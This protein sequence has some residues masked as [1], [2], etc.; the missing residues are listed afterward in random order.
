MNYTITLNE[1]KKTRYPLLFLLFAFLFENKFTEIIS[2]LLVK[3]LFSS[4]IYS[5]KILDAFF[6]LSICVIVG[7]LT[8]Y[9]IKGYKISTLLGY[10][11]IAVSIIH[12]K[13]RFFSFE[14]SY[15]HL[16]TK[17]LSSFAYIDILFALVISITI[18]YLVVIISSFLK[19]KNTINST[20]GFYSDV[21]LNLINKELDSLNRLEY[22]KELKIKLLATISTEASFAIGI[23]GK[24][25]SGKTT[26]ITTLE[27]LLKKERE[28]IQ[29]KFNP[30]MAGSTEKIVE[31]FFA[32]LSSTLGSYDGNLKN[33][34]ITYSKD[35]IKSMDFNNMT[36]LKNLFE[37][38]DKNLSLNDQYE[39][40]STS[41][42]K[43]NKRLIIYIDDVDR[44][45]KKEVLEVLR[46]I[47]NTANFKNT[48]FIVAFDRN[49]LTASI[50]D[51]LA[52]NTDTYIEKIFQLE[53]Y[54]PISIDK[55][56][57][58]KIFYQEL[59][60]YLSAKQKEVIEY[61]KSPTE[62]SFWGAG[63]QIPNIEKYIINL[64]DVKRFLNVFLLNFDRIK[65]NVYLPDYIAI[66]ILRLKFPDVYYELY[67]NRSKYLNSGKNNAY[68]TEAGKL[69]LNYPDK[70]EM[71]LENSI[72][73]SELKSNLAFYSLSDK[74]ADDSVRLVSSI[75]PPN[76]NFSRHKRSLYNN[77]LSI[78]E[79][80]CFDR[81][82]D[83]SLEGRLNQIE[84]E[85]A[86][87]KDTK[88]FKAFIEKS[89]ANNIVTDLQ[90]SLE[91]TFVNN[92]EEFKKLVLGIVYFA[93][94]PIPNNIRY[95]NGFNANSFI[96]I[97]GGIQKEHNEVIKII[98]KENESEYTKFIWELFRDPVNTDYSFY[99]FQFGIYL[100]K[101]Y[102]SYEFVVK[103]QEIK[104]WCKQVY[105]DLLSR[106]KKLNNEVWNMYHETMKVYN[107]T[108]I[109]ERK[110]ILKLFK[111]FILKNDFAGF[112]NDLIDPCLKHRENGKKLSDFY[113]LLYENDDLFESEIKQQTENKEINLEFLD[114]FQRWKTRNGSECVL[115]FPFKF[116]TRGL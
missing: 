74:T 15:L 50:N 39:N 108:E 45:D 102:Y 18:Y 29:L 106:N 55:K 42:K 115:D 116:L 59:S 68:S 53:Y 103:H 31:L 40:I 23:I 83:F 37:N 60:N 4:V 56:I 69:T 46:L 87:S 6:L 52:G 81:Y 10:W 84:Y 35:L 88:E 47:R 85:Q 34:I 92:E 100:L 93:N 114:F 111:N 67:H 80:S 3:P 27:N 79:P 99:I 72:L 97:I 86:F 105:I 9:L 98:F 43:L 22:I 2:F 109:N 78:S 96:K 12:V 51:A 19:K 28:V 70:I 71:K 90:I 54:L 41:I 30:W 14:F 107:E 104:D 95:K 112:L 62:T 77:H 110:E 24:W 38:N 57:T 94:I 65:H 76:D 64:R 13:Y 5:T 82:F 49:Y 48:F 89:I 32:D 17:W 21:P 113:L 61:L 73:F 75:F 58:T 91:N 44:L 11:L 33:K 36:L 20:L 8:Y 26:F 16:K 1:L 101:N 25:G 66:N 63:E 7:F